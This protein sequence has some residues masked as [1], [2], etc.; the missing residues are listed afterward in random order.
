MGPQSWPVERDSSPALAHMCEYNPLHLE[1][2]YPNPFHNVYHEF[3]GVSKSAL[4][5]F[6]GILRQVVFPLQD[7][8]FFGLAADEEHRGNIRL[9]CCRW[10]IWAPKILSAASA[11]FLV[12]AFWMRADEEMAERRSVSERLGKGKDVSFLRQRTSCR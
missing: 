4:P 6:D 11:P 3:V 8:R 7:P 9:L 5:R 10:D 1:V 2:A 12:E